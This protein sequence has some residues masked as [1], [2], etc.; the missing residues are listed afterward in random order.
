MIAARRLRGV[1]VMTTGRAMGIVRRQGWFDSG[2]GGRRPGAGRKQEKAR[3]S[4][5]HRRRGFH[6]AHEPVH[7]VIRVA[8]DIATMR[9]RDVFGVVRQAM[10]VTRKRMEQFRIVHVS[11]QG[12]HL[13]LIV[14]AID[15][16]ALAR[17]M[18]GFQVS[19]AKRLNRRLGRRGAVFIDRYHRAP[20]R[21]PRQCRNV[22]EYVFNNWRKHDEDRLLPGWRLDPYSTA[23]RFA[24][25]ADGVEPYDGMPQLPVCAP[26]TW[27][28]A[29][30]WERAGPLDPWRVPAGSI[31]ASSTA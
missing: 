12:T 28:L 15:G 31:R 9:D 1:L 10:L 29:A 2:W 26:R 23:A 22:L 8:S 13:H 11:L 18:Q 17:G 19:C 16:M 5:P 21:T 4:S 3:K 24:G 14:E 27:L 6:R 7:V 20:I 25:W 30:G